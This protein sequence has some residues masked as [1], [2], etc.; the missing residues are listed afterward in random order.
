VENANRTL[1]VENCF[2]YSSQKVM[3]KI[4][5]YCSVNLFGKTLES[6]QMS[7]SELIHNLHYL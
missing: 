6:I 3:F 5:N 2:V 7:S 1:L 4:A